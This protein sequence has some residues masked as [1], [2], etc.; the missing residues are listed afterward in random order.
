MPELK[1]VQLDNFIAPNFEIDIDK[2]KYKNQ[3]KEQTRL[4]NMKVYAETGEWPGKKA[5]KKRTE[6]WEQTKKAKLDAKSK[7]EL[8]KAKK[9]RKKAA[10]MENADN[11]LNKKRKQQFTQEDLDELAND[12]RLFKRLKKNKITEDE[13]DKE[14]GL[15]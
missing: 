15:E 5:F 10:E 8:R 13:F 11:K 2:L 1:N 3:Q 14:M 6:S 12:I 9:Q 4:N 7:K